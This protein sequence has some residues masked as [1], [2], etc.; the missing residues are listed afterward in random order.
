MVSDNLSFLFAFYLRLLDFERIDRFVYFRVDNRIPLTF[1]NDVDLKTW[2][3]QG[4]EI[5]GEGD[6]SERDANAWNFYGSGQREDFIG[7]HS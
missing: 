5:R 6:G 1:N 4:E 7:I 2:T 3:L